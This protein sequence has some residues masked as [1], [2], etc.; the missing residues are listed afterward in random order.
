MSDPASALSPK[1]S[2]RFKRVDNLGAYRIP[3]EKQ[4]RLAKMPCFAHLLGFAVSAA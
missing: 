4:P 2:N 1:A 3:L